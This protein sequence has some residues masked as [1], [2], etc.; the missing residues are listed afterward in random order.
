ML[1]N[2][3]IFIFIFLP[4]TLLG[5]Y[6]LGRRNSNLAILWLTL[7]SLFFYAWWDVRYLALILFSIVFNYLAARL[8]SDDTK[9]EKTR[10]RLLMGSI[11]ANLALLGYFKYANFFVDNVNDLIGTDWTLQRIILPLAISFFTFQSLFP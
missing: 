11:V 3:Q 1:F 8:V 6:L 10:Y 5:Y 7:A 9:G 2:S 4:I